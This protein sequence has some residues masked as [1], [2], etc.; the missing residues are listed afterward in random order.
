MEEKKSQPKKL[1]LS[2]TKQEMLE[3][4][5]AVVKQLEAQRE[6]ELKPEK[7]LEEKRA[8]EVIQVAD[9]LSSDGVSKEIGSLKM[10]MGKVLAQIS[11]RL[12]DEIGK[13]RAV[14][15]AIAVK[16]KEL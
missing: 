5:N 1:S 3:A 16:E 11:D 8:K 14:Q 13:F 9:S 7:K 12:E 6:A 10:E 2:S 4:Y 15:G